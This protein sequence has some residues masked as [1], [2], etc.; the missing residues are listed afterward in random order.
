MSQFVAILFCYIIKNMKRIKHIILNASLAEDIYYECFTVI[1]SYMPFSSKIVRTNK[2]N[3][4]TQALTKHDV[5]CIR[6][7]LDPCNILSSI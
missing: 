5:N 3:I 7:N 4:S 6:I 1:S 2:K